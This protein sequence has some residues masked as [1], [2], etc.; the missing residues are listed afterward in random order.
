[1]LLQTDLLDTRC[2][3]RH[4]KGHHKRGWLSKKNAAV[5]SC[6]GSIESVFEEL[7]LSDTGGGG[8]GNR[9]ELVLFVI[10]PLLCMTRP[11][12]AIAGSSSGTMTFRGCCLLTNHTHTQTR[13][14]PNTA[15]TQR[16]RDRQKPVPSQSDNYVI[17]YNSRPPPLFPFP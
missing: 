3:Q 14:A 15:H 16:A 1:V 17:L 13:A 6:L 7:F 12:H 2:T 8:V 11:N 5:Y 9:E 4:R 10:T